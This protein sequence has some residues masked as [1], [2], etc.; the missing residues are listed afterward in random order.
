VASSIC[1][2]ATNFSKLRKDF[3][4]YRYTE[5]MNELQLEDLQT[6]G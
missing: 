3:V 4:Y 1:L 2:L 6:A 5:Q